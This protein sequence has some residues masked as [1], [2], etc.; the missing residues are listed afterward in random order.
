M[1]RSNKM[2]YAELQ[3]CIVESGRKAGFYCL[4][5][6]DQAAGFSSLSLPLQGERLAPPAMF[7][8]KSPDTYPDRQPGLILAVEAEARNLRLPSEEGLT[9]KGRGLFLKTT[10]RFPRT[11]G[12]TAEA[13]AFPIDELQE[14]IEGF[15]LAH[16]DTA[17]V[18]FKY[19]PRW[20]ILLEGEISYDIEA[21]EDSSEVE[22][23]INCSLYLNIRILAA[24]AD[25]FT[26]QVTVIN[27]QTL[28]WHNIQNTMSHL[29]L[30]LHWLEMEDAPETPLDLVED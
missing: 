26:E 10:F 25:T 8:L 4:N 19:R 22:F 21:E 23:E 15:A 12:Y 3:R 29:I 28:T 13:A 1:A 17:R 7:T 14:R 2:N 6:G 30:L 24:P 20:A 11:V 9:L 5:D 18:L 16:P 27:E